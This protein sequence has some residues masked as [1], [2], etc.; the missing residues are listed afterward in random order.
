M[1]VFGVILFFII[2]HHVNGPLEQLP[3]STWLKKAF[4]SLNQQPSVK[5][6]C[7]PLPAFPEWCQGNGYF[8]PRCGFVVT[9]SQAEGRWKWCQVD[10][11]LFSSF[12]VPTR[13]QIGL[14]R[15]RSA[16]PTASGIQTKGQNYSEGTVATKWTFKLVLLFMQLIYVHFNV[17]FSVGQ[18]GTDYE[19]QPGGVPWWLGRDPLSLQL[20]WFGWRAQLRHDSVV[21]GK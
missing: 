20:L 19:W 4:G 8:W 9:V 13:L 6:G 2:C 3:S 17:S 11:K 14:S 1:P 21:C 18:S 7:L 10:K 15:L 16:N 12:F 5:L